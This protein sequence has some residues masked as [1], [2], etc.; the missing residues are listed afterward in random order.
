[1]SAFVFIPFNCFQLSL[2]FILLIKS[3]IHLFITFCTLIHLNIYTSRFL[4]RKG[5][6]R[7]LNLS[8]GGG[9]AFG[10]YPEKSPPPPLRSGRAEAYSRIMNSDVHHSEYISGV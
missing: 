1:M 9:G 10:F 3:F 6:L 7:P 4:L 5:S 8:K 2:S